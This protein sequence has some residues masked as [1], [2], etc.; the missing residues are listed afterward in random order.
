MEKPK[1]KTVHIKMDPA[2]AEKAT[3]LAAK[4]G[5]SLSAYVRMLISQKVYEDAL[6]QV[7][8]NSS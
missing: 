4:L 5:L 6:L 3:S 2:L 7:S 1:N 8:S